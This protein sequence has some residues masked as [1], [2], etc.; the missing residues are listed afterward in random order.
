M[1]YIVLIG[2]CLAVVSATPLE[3]AEDEEGQQYYM[4]PLSRARRSPGSV[5]HLG[6]N[7]RG[8]GVS[9]QGNILNKNGHQLDGG[10][11]ASKNYQS[12][13]LRPDQ[14]GGR[15]DYNH[16]PSR[17]SAFATADHARR[18]GTDVSAGIRH[19][20]YSSKNFNVGVGGDYGR[21][22]GGPGGN[23]RHQFGGFI[24]G[25]GRF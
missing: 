5:T 19:D 6:A 25:S 11:Y 24:R 12:H 14:F 21:H 20:I 18:Y 13:G 1:K 17:T 22:L 8:F 7:E 4:V 15:L 2:F 3:I 9:H 10:A 16:A 23:G